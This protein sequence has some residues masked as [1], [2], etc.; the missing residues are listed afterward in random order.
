MECPP[1]QV[2]RVEVPAQ[3][4]GST[5]LADPEIAVF[6][7]PLAE[8]DEDENEDLIEGPPLVLDPDLELKVRFLDLNFARYEVVDFTRTP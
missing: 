8:E 4:A 2:S 7:N 6:T 5:A 1:D 3:F